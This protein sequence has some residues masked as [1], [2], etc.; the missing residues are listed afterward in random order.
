[1]LDPM[2]RKE[3][4]RAYA[5]RDW[6]ALAQAKRAY[7]HAMQPA[8]RIFAADELRRFAESTHA[9]WPTADDRRRDLD[10]HIRLARLLLRA[11]SH[12]NR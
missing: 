2:T 6:N 5:K 12:E 11:A 7:W 4:L 3:Q 1:M 9:G 8:D 10:S